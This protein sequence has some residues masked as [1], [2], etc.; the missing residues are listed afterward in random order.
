MRLCKAIPARITRPSGVQPLVGAG[1]MPSHKEQELLPKKENNSPRTGTALNRSRLIWTKCGGHRPPFPYVTERLSTVSSLNDLLGTPR[2]AVVA[3]LT[4]LVNRTVDSQSGISG[5]ALKG[6][7]GAAKKMDADIVSKGLNRLLPEL[8]SSL[9]S[10]WQ[11]FQASGESD[12]GAYLVAH[13]DEVVS[14]IM[15]VADNASEK[16]NVPALAKAYKAIRG[17]A[18]NFI[19]PALPE[20]GAV[21]AKH[22]G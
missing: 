8:A 2:E 6:A 14:A 4:D 1:R 9:D 11:G 10:Q 5:M 7:V 12:F 19:E 16:I 21:I 17:K 18:A 3:D 20:L 22:M 13:K 15:T